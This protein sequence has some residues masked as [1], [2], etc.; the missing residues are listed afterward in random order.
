MREKKSGSAR[1]PRAGFG[2]LAETHFSFDSDRGGDL[3]TVKK[4]REPETGSPARGT[5]ALP[6]IVT[7]P[8]LRSAEGG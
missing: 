5:R 7:A 2:A 1:V 3:E 8:L 6:R 4:V